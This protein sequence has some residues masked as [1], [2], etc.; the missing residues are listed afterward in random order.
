MGNC[1]DS[2]FASICG[3]IAFQTLKSVIFLEHMG[4]GERALTKYRH[5]YHV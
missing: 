5:L 2:S 1:M 4:K 3:I